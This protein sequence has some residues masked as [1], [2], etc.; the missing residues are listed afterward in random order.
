MRL[1]HVRRECKNSTG[2]CDAA[3]STVQ[4]EEKGVEM[5]RSSRQEA[6]LGTS[7]DAICN[8]GSRRDKEQ[9][10]APVLFRKL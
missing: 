5:E 2:H 3:V 8:A 4:E 10:K 6:R 9:S 7:A 1:L